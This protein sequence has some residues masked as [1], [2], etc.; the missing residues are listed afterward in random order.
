M[1]IVLLCFV[2]IAVVFVHASDSVG[3]GRGFGD[4]YEWYQLDA[5]LEK[6][7]ELNKPAMIVFHKSWC[8]AC[9]SLGRKFTDSEV[10]KSLASNFVMVNV[11]DD[12]DPSDS[13]YTPDGGYIPRI[14]FANPD[15]SLRT[16]IQSANDRYRHFF[17]D[18]SQVADAMRRAMGEQP[19]APEPVN[20]TGQEEL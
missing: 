20:E 17:A 8:G 1:K 18:D 5:G 7:K 19:K 9:K 6:A 4:D 16:D 13:K 14:F 10:I 12:E 3:L 2:I 15:G 11:H